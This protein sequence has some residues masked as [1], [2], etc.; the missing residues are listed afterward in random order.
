MIRTWNVVGLL[1]LFIIS[2]IGKEK[3]RVNSFGIFHVDEISVSGI[4]G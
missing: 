2:S 3:F 4:D 1:Y